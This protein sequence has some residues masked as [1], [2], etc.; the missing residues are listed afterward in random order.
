[1]KKLILLFLFLSSLNLSAQQYLAA[2]KQD[3][4]WGGSW[5]YIDT[6]GNW[7]IKPI[8]QEASAFSE[9]FAKV[10]YSGNYGFIDKKGNWITKPIYPLA[11]DFNNGHAKVAW[12]GWGI[13]DTTGKYYLKPKYHYV[14]EF[15]E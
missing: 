7:V 15:S 9:G 5:G 6:T 11:S 12:H 4:P 13:I 8:Y 1:M 3:G 10:K 14:G 2:A